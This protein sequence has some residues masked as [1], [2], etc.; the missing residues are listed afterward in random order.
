ML[1]MPNSTIEAFYLC[2][3]F[4]GL[5][6]LRETANSLGE[7]V[8]CHPPEL[9]AALAANEIGT[10]EGAAPLSHQIMI[11]THWYSP[12]TYFFRIFNQGK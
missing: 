1:T 11:T 8:T 10:P 9:N 3:T 4:H 6:G 7:N 2:K 12:F 5:R